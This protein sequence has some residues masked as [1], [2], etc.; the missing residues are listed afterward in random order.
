MRTVLTY[1]LLLF[2]ILRGCR[3]GETTNAKKDFDHLQLALIETSV[4][5]TLQL[6]HGLNTETY[7]IDFKPVGLLKR[8]II[9]SFLRK[10]P[11]IV[12]TN[13]DSLLQHDTTWTKYQYF[14]NPVI[15]FEGVQIQ[16]DGTILIRTSKTKSSDGAF[17]TKIILKQDGEKYKC[18]KSEIT[19]IS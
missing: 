18:L 19:W 8:N 15:R 1:L 7:A 9:D 10:N 2:S 11:T 13:L 14:K 6:D 4:D 17:G 5:A 12:E 16:N 3:Q